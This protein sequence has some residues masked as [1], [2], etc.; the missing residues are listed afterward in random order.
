MNQGQI[1]SKPRETILIQQNKAML[2]GNEVVLTLQ[3]LKLF[4]VINL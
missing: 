3:V 1:I 4:P 2:Q